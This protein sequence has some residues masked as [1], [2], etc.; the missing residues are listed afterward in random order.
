MVTAAA[1]RGPLGAA[2]HAAERAGTA[3]AVVAESPEG[4]ATA[5]VA[6]SPQ[7]T[8]TAAEKLAA[9]MPAVVRPGWSCPQRLALPTGKA[10]RRQH[11]GSGSSPRTACEVGFRGVCAAAGRGGNSSARHQHC[12]KVHTRCTDL[13]A[14]LEAAR[15]QS[16]LQSKSTFPMPAPRQH[17]P[18]LPGA[19]GTPRGFPVA[20]AMVRP[21][22]AHC[23]QF[24]GLAA[25][26]LRRFLHLL[27]A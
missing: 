19:W 26:A 10:C 27:L 2:I 8:A 22:L 9:L 23:A 16:L 5:A 17:P 7:G 25:A 18:A 11:L 21:L 14:Q 12:W 4:T 24:S 6:E 3:T 13:C 1:E 15:I 20:P